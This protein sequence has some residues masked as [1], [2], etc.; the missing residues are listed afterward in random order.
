MK[1]RFRLTGFARFFIV[2]L[3]VV[4]LA[5]IIASYYNGEDGLENIRRIVGLD[6]TEQAS[7]PV[8]EDSVDRVTIKNDNETTGESDRISL[9]EQDN[10]KLKAQL[11]DMSVELKELRADIDRLESLVSK[12]RN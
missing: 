6:K 9:L 1:R 4:P 11:L 5:Y 10:V 8:S 2:M 12:R 3:F 7:E